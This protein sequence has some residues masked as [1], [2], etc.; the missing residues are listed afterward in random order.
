VVVAVD[1][2]VV[3]SCSKASNSGICQGHFV[4]K[5]KVRVIQVVVVM[6]DSVRWT[7][8]TSPFDFEATSG[9]EQPFQHQLLEQIT[10]RTAKTL[11]INHEQQGRRRLA[12][13]S[14]HLY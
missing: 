6:C 14:I 12:S 9:F 11:A 1:I 4:S 5:K 8:I 3:F 13:S 7:Q 10:K 2:F